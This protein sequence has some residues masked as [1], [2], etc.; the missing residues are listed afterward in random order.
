M[1]SGLQIPWHNVAH[2]R[3]AKL[4]HSKCRLFLIPLKR[5]TH[6]IPTPGMDGPGVLKTQRTESCICRQFRMVLCNCGLDRTYKVCDCMQMRP[7]AATRTKCVY[8]ATKSLNLHPAPAR[9]TVSLRNP[10]VKA[11]E[12]GGRYNT[13]L[14]D[15]VG[16]EQVG[17]VG[18]EVGVVVEE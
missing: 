8:G 9:V 4:C 10:L 2:F 18:L 12:S 15:G 14:R 16:L 11:P 17:Q 1:A 5:R 6:P 3:C 13:H 7:D